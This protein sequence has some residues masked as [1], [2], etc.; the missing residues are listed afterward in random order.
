MGSEDHRKPGWTLLFQKANRIRGV[1]ILLLGLLVAEMVLLRATKDE[2]TIAT[3][4]TA[5]AVAKKDDVQSSL[6]IAVSKCQLWRSEPLQGKCDGTKSTDESRVFTTALDCEK[7]CC[8]SETCV[9]F[10]FRTKEGCLFGGDTRL[11]AEKDGPSSWCEPRPPAM[12]HG[13]W[14]K[15]QKEGTPVQGACDKNDWNPKELSG[16]C[17]GLGSKKV[18]PRHTPEACRDACCANEECHLWQWRQDAGCFYNAKGH[19]CAE[20]SPLDFEK[21]IGK[22][23]VVEGRTYQPYAYSEDFADMAGSESVG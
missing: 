10:Q 3:A 20:A 14:I 5:A 1:L 15:V 19:G 6:A 22:R 21:F 13:Q 18:I 9:A 16:Q 7:A 23:K 11:G 12:W 17:F 4:T 2:D 8:D